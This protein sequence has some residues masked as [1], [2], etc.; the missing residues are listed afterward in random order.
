MSQRD[1]SGTPMFIH[2]VCLCDGDNSLDI[3]IESESEDKAEAIAQVLGALRDGRPR[4]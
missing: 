2:Y 3:T 1:D 4:G